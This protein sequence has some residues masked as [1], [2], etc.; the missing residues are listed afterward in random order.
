M[1]KVSNVKLK[2]DIINQ[3]TAKL[4]ISWRTTFTQQEV[5]SHT[6]FV[7]DIFI[8]NVDGF[9]DPDVRRRRLGTAWDLSNNN[10]I[11]REVSFSVERSFLDEDFRVFGFGDTTDEWVAEVKT[12]VYSP[13]ES[14]DTS[15]QLRM[16]FGKS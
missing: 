1:S 11:D 6:V 10:P 9:G 12:R 15:P 16:E 14:T 3:D 2:G 8:Q 7:Y 4:T 5:L 13:I